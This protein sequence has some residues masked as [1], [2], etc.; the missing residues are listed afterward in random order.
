MG[1]ADAAKR[2]CAEGARKRWL[3]HH[4]ED[5]GGCAGG[6]GAGDDPLH[7]VCLGEDEEGLGE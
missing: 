4:R 7:G 1:G 6:P 2:A 5:G 3:E